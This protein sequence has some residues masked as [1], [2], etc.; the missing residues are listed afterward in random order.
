MLGPDIDANA[1]IDDLTPDF[2]DNSDFSGDEG[3]VASSE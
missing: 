3:W 1:T 2:D